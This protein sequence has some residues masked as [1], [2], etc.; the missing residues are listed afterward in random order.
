MA[1]L[2]PHLDITLVPP[3]TWNANS[4]PPA[5]KVI[6]WS[7][8]QDPLTGSLSVQEVTTVKNKLV[9]GRLQSSPD[10]STSCL[11]HILSLSQNQGTIPHWL[12]T[13]VVN[14]FDELSRRY[15]R[16]PL[17]FPAL[18]VFPNQKKG[19]LNANY[20]GQLAREYTIKYQF[21]PLDSVYWEKTSNVPAGTQPRRVYSNKLS[22]CDNWDGFKTLTLNTLIGGST[23]PETYQLKFS[24]NGGAGGGVWAATGG[25][26]INFVPNR[27]PTRIVFDD[28]NLNDYLAYDQQVVRNIDIYKITAAQ[29]ATNNTVVDGVA[30][31][32]SIGQD[33]NRTLNLKCKLK[34][35]AADGGWYDVPNASKTV[36]IVGN[37]GYQTSLSEQ[38]TWS[39]DNLD[40]GG[41]ENLE[42]LMANFTGS[43]FLKPSSNSIRINLIRRTKLPTRI[44]FNTINNYY[45]GDENE[46]A[47]FTNNQSSQLKDL[48]GDGKIDLSVTLE[49]RILSTKNW[50]TLNGY[51]SGI[52]VFAL[53]N[54]GYGMPKNNSVNLTDVDP[55][56]VLM[57]NGKLTLRA[58][59][60]AAGDNTY[61]SCSTADEFTWNRIEAGDGSR[62]YK[63]FSHGSV[64]P[65]IIRKV[66][67]YQV[68]EIKSCSGKGW[69]LELP[70][71]QNPFTRPRTLF[72]DQVT[73]LNGSPNKF[74]PISS[75]IPL[76]SAQ[77]DL[78]Q[79]NY[80][81]PETA[82]QGYFRGYFTKSVLTTL[83][84]KVQSQMLQLTQGCSK[85]AFKTRMPG[86]IPLTVS[87]AKAKPPTVASSLG[88]NQTY[89]L[90]CIIE[91]EPI[92]R[93]INVTPSGTTHP[94]IS[95]KEI[96]IQLRVFV[97]SNKNIITN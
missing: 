8:Y 39:Y 45:M 82:K 58:N 96:P 52:K 43:T 76:K 38:D 19:L 61:D 79:L 4:N 34:Y 64:T 97:D 46:M 26:T 48:T 85:L 7:V 90:K 81:A 68:H 93:Q 69:T 23:S 3:K 13:Y 33:N 12:F 11:G 95:K 28:E 37:N 51:D 65:V 40:A 21:V 94:M 87:N 30:K 24:G 88:F 74:E 14:G 59:L 1:N 6:T 67:N 57:G 72:P 66:K 84:T 86:N 80:V 60:T 41:N 27:F 55:A 15:W 5:P 83:S 62:Y 44:K 9:Y 10:L 54:Q 50:V 63:T 47:S 18:P 31:W 49:T 77:Y 22:N 20:C 29:S 35:Q 56:N 42:Y 16:N 78:T 32:K 75:S 17:P 71:I 73:S 36:N 89:S 92:I 91:E 53:E 70:K 25:T 2:T